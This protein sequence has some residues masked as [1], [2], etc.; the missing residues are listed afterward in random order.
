[1]E[2][3]PVSAKWALCER[4]ARYAGTVRIGK[5]VLDPTPKKVE[6]SYS[7][8]TVGFCCEYKVV[9]I[10]TRIFIV[11]DDSL[12]VSQLEIILSRLQ[13]EICGVAASG[14]DFLE[15]IDRQSPDLVL[16][17]IGLPGDLDGF[18]VLRE[19]RRLHPRTP[20][21]FLTAYSDS[22]TLQKVASV[23]PDGYLQKPVTEISLQAAID[24]AIKKRRLEE[25]NESIERLQ[26]VARMSGGFAHHF[27]NLLT[28]VMGNLDLAEGKIG[29]ENSEIH[30]HIRSSLEATKRCAELVRNLL[31]ASG[32]YPVVRTTIDVNEELESIISAYGTTRAAGGVVSDLDSNALLVS[33]DLAQFDSVMIGLIENAREA[34]QQGGAIRIRSSLVQVNVGEKEAG[35]VNLDVGRYARIDVSDDGVGIDESELKKV[36]EPFYTTKDV[37]QGTGLGLSMALGLARQAGGDLMLS[38]IRG[39]GTTVSV[40]LPII[41]AN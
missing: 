33:V 23:H 37:G 36:I 13:Y 4:P 1:M 6:S 17:D 21:I 14:Q 2:P 38:S 30:S 22:E 31:A 28:V 8:E 35:L 26:L 39:S 5:K 34:T 41:T 16:L 18:E 29:D 32:T 27:N 7:Q 11:D 25:K 20:V 9:L 12:L 24:E 3:L 19:F 10:P 15:N 40:Y